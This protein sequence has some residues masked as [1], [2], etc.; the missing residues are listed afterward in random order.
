MS[1]VGRTVKAE[2]IESARTRAAVLLSSAL[3]AGV[4]AVVAFVVGGGWGVTLGLFLV[5]TA[6]VL[7]VAGGREVGIA[8]GQAG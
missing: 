1:P 7:V 5:A 3:V 8:L 4:L 2:R 6:F